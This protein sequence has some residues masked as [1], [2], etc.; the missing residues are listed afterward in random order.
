MERNTTYLASRNSMGCHTP[1]DLCEKKGNVSTKINVLKTQHII[2]TGIDL[3][4]FN[5]SSPT[6]DN[7]RKSFYDTN[8]AILPA[9]V[10][11]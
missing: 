6:S 7:Y 2:M 8:N 10:Q 1:S 3:E 4:F 11:S 9:L 5:F